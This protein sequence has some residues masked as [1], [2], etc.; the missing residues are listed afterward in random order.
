MS[1][2]AKPPPALDCNCVLRLI[3]KIHAPTKAKLLVALN[4]AFMDLALRLGLICQEVI[5][6]KFKTFGDGSGSELPSARRLLPADEAMPGT[7]WLGD[8]I[9][10]E[11]MPTCYN[12]FALE[13][14]LNLTL[15]CM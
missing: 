12:E 11:N 3:F 5:P 1:G 4:N 14:R 7:A 15:L 6:L 2:R 13:D 9:Q 8:A 10:G